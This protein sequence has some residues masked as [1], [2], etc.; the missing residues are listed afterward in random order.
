MTAHPQLC[1]LLLLPLLPTE[2]IDSVGIIRSSPVIVLD[3]PFQ[4][5]NRHCLNNIPNEISYSI[6]VL[7]A[8]P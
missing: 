1:V 4:L 8:V 2:F 5:L 7:P 6:V 3:P